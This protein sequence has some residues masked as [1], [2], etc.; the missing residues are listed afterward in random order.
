MLT[1][2]STNSDQQHALF[3]RSSNLDPWN[4]R[5]PQCRSRFLL[6]HPLPTFR[7]SVRRVH[8]LSSWLKMS[9]KDCSRRNSFCWNKLHSRILA[10]SMCL[11]ILILV[12]II[13]IWL[14]LRPTKPKFLL[15]DVSLYMLNLSAPNLLSSYLQITI[16]SRNPNDRFGIYYDNLDTFAEYKHQQITAVAALPVGYQGHNDVEIWSQNLYGIDV[17][18]APFAADSITQEVN[19]GLLLI[20]VRLEGRL[21]WKVGSWISSHYH[22]YASCPALLTADN[23]K[24]GGRSS[25]Y[26]FEQRTPCIVN[27]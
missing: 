13:V 19:A 7:P 5:P 15:Q 16:S 9:E 8:T 4:I 10:F 12:I 27:I 3:S 24:S 23:G 2:L 14:L 18:I 20:Y 26:R 17:S 1:I 25:A 22:I 11:I 21:R 6:L